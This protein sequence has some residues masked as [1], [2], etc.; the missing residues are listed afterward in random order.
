MPI[1]EVLIYVSAI[2]YI[3]PLE[4]KLHEG[5]TQPFLLSTVSSQ[6][7]RVPGVQEGPSQTSIHFLFCLFQVFVFFFFLDLTGIGLDLIYLLNYS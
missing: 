3:F 7:L 6:P 2:L 5:R 4:C 1:N